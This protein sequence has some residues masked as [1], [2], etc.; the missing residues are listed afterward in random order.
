MY[1]R[2][3]PVTWQNPA[4]GLLYEPGSVF[5]LVTYGAALDLGAIT[6]DQ[7]FEDTGKRKVGDKIDHE[8]TAAPAGVGDG[9]G[10]AWPSR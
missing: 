8:L 3:E 10:C 2:A 1:D 7:K 5:K 4:V 9:L 6:P